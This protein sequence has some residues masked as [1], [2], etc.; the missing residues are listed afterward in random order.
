MTRQLLLLKPT[1]WKRVVRNN[2]TVLPTP[3]EVIATV[4]QLAAAC[5][6]YKGIMFTNKDGNI[7]R[8][9]EDDEDDIAG[10]P[11]DGT[12]GNSE[13]T[14]V[15][16]NS[17]E[18]QT[19]TGVPQINIEDNSPEDEGNTDYTECN[20]DNIGNSPKNEGNSNHDQGNTNSDEGNGPGNTYNNWDTPSKNDEGYGN[21]RNM[22]D[23]EISIE[24]RSTEDP[25]ITIND[26]SIIEEIN[27]AQINNN[28]TNEE[29]IENNREWTTVANNN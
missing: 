22:Y 3:A 24:N 11:N 4:R 7:I 9:D 23:D 10:N 6:K 20:I 5:K 18:L 8:D 25:Q 21:I 17:N 27:N 13:I 29:A 14:G 26:I 12:V 28:E 19:T 15:H 16:G 2:W 1:H